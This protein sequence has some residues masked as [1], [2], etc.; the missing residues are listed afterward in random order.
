MCRNYTPKANSK[1]V[2]TFISW[3]Y[4]SYIWVNILRVCPLSQVM[5]KVLS[6]IQPNGTHFNDREKILVLALQFSTF[7][8]VLSPFL[9]QEIPYSHLELCVLF[10]AVYNTIFKNSYGTYN[11]FY[12]WSF[13]S[14]HKRFLTR[15]LKR[16]G[17]KQLVLTSYFHLSASI[18]ILLNFPMLSVRYFS[19]LDF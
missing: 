12:R 15:S 10:F 1:S 5:F 11:V 4:P 8:K 13:A 3:P 18:E 7:W 14:Y 9:I 17:T 16:S 2:Q 19:L 6:T